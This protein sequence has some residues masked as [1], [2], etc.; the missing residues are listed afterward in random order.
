[1]KQNSKWTYHPGLITSFAFS[2]EMWFQ[3]QSFPLNP[4]SDNSILG[5]LGQG[6]EQVPWGQEGIQS[7]DP[8]FIPH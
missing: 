6:R 3:E 8:H 7:S 1:M 2:S 5:G 4:E